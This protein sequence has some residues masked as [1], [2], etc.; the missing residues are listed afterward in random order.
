MLSAVDKRENLAFS[1]N[2]VLGIWKE[3]EAPDISSI[4]Q[5]PRY[6]LNNSL[7]EAITFERA[8]NVR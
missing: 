6:H 4:L 3:Q 2:S 8:E 7:D 5:L 1:A